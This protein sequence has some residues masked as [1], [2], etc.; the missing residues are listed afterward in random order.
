[1]NIQFQLC[2]LF[3]LILL[4]IFYK[5]HKTLQLY[6]EKVFYRAICV[7]II[8]LTLDILS[9]VVIHF[10]QDLFNGFVYFICRSYIVSLIWGARAA[11]VYVLTDLFSEKKH[12]RINS[13]IL[14]V[15]LIQ[16]VII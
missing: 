16:S 14:A 2:G 8:S 3:V 10:R 1:M 4:F 13:F 7:M 11:L 6:K 15:G 5:S 9:L 12:K